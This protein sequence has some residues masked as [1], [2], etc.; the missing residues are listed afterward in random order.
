M[1]VV[2]VVES[3]VVSA[4]ENLVVSAAENLVVS[5]VG[6]PV[7]S[8]AENLVVSVARWGQGEPKALGRV[9]VEELGVRAPRASTPSEHPETMC[10]GGGRA[11]RRADE[12]N[13]EESTSRDAMSPW[14]R[15]GVS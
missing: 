8:A 14:R 2:S 3:L 12:V 9:R 13:A 7:V 5:V 1:L 10:A 15:S 11:W 4:A 6:N